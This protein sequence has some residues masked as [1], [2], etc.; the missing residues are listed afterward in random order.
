MFRTWILGFLLLV[1]GIFY[2]LTNPY[3]YGDAL[4]YA[5][6][7]AKGELHESDP[8]HLIWRPLAL[9]VWSIF[10]IAP[11]KLSPLATLQILSGIGTALGCIATYFLALQFTLSKGVAYAASLLVAGSNFCLSY[12]GSGSAYGPA[13]GLSTL[14]I[15]C[16]LNGSSQRLLGGWLPAALF[17]W[18]AT[19]I[20]GVSI[21]T[22]PAIGL[23]V[24]FGAKHSL[25]KGVIDGILYSIVT[26]LFIGAS[27][28]VG[29][30]YA[31]NAGYS[32]AF[33]PWLHQSSHGI[34]SQISIMSF[35]RA[36]L[37]FCSSFVYLGSFGTGVKALL[38]GQS[39]E[40]HLARFALP[41]GTLL[42]FLVGIALGKI[43]LLKT[44]KKISDEARLLLMLTTVNFI[45]VTAFAISWQGSDIERFCLA[46]PLCSISICYGLSQFRSSSEKFLPW[47]MA[48]FVTIANLS[49]NIA[50]MQ[51]SHGGIAMGL[52]QAARASMPEGSL[53]VLSGQ[54][55]GASIWAPTMYF[56][57]LQVHS[58]LYD[59]QNNDPEGWQKRLLDKVNQTLAQGKKIALLSDFLG[60]LT[61]G[62]IDLN[63]KENPIPAL[64]QVSS[65]FKDWHKGST[66]KIGR[67]T[68]VEVS[69]PQ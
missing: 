59:V 10:G 52:G 45:C 47:A 22:L 9:G 37:G 35:A 31:M 55:L 65:L 51:I 20:W 63:T 41:I 38:T 7:I 49:M 34:K 24:I 21:L 39:Q 64:D 18:L 17:A 29:Y 67:F 12:G 3:W 2:F 26:L 1:L 48:G 32:D 46:I 43:G 68:F 66:F 27:C 6:D 61:P 4:W 30:H 40:A 53:I 50:P 44:L 28:A 8:G 62:G 14:A 13:M 42:M 15:C 5:L 58:L 56:Y 19:A 54:A 23:A 33:L 57:N 36:A 60:E 11:L 16:A 25:F 69:P